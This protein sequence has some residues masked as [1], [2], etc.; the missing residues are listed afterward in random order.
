VAKTQDASAYQKLDS[1]VQVWIT[2]SIQQWIEVEPDE[3][4]KLLRSLRIKP[5]VVV[6]RPLIQVPRTTTRQSAPAFSGDQ[7][8]V[9]GGVTVD[10]AVC[11]TADLLSVADLSATG[12]VGHGVFR[13]ALMAKIREWE[14]S[15]LPPQPTT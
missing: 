9:G 13:Q 3:A 6:L 11:Q 7:A 12:A 8:E 1:G 4:G 2:Q 5:T 15:T 14:V 10:A